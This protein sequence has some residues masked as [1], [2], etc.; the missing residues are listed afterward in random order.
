M[1]MPK[2]GRQYSMNDILNTAVEE[3]S[4]YLTFMSPEHRNYEEGGAFLVSGQLANIGAGASIYIQVKTGNDGRTTAVKGS[5]VTCDQI[6]V[7]KVFEAPT[8]TDGTI[9]LTVAQRDRRHD[10]EDLICPT[11]FY[12]NPTNIT[13]EG[14]LIKTQVFGGGS[15]QATPSLSNIDDLGFNYKSN[16][17]YL[18]KLTNITAQATT[19]VAILQNI[20]M[21]GRPFTSE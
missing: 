12:T 8:L 10:D 17:N 16:T 6:I 21:V 19:I 2:S 15:N 13:Q 3:G 20:Y 7:A 9:E 1:P 18:I 4:G 14:L 5:A 11:K